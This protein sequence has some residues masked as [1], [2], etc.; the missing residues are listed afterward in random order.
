VSYTSSLMRVY[1]VQMT[2]S[3]DNTP[4]ATRRLHET[5]VD[6]T[7][8]HKPP[9]SEWLCGYECIGVPPL[10][11]PR[12][13]VGVAEIARYFS[14]GKST[15]SNWA[16]R[17]RTNGMPLPVADPDCGTIYDISQI[18]VWWANWEPIRGTKVGCLPTEEGSP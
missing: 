8:A 10:V 13:L 3:T 16:A 5:C 4:D 14:V 1:P 7:P 18:I 12:N 15:V 17:R 6:V 2:E 9:G 11:D